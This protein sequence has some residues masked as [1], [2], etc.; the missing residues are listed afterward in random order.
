MTDEPDFIAILPTVRR[1]LFLVAVMHFR[2][3]LDSY[4]TTTCHPR[5]LHMK[6]ARRLAN[7]WA[8]DLSLE[9]R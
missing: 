5:T 1:D 9:V 7:R 3:D 4:I 6:Q 2:K 8:E